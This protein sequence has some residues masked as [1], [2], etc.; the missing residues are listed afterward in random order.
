MGTQP[1]AKKFYTPEEYLAMEETAEYKSEYYQGEIF[2]MAGGSIDYNRIV[3]N[4]ENRMSKAFEGKDCEV[5]FNDMRLRVDAVDLFT[6]PDLIVICGQPKFYENRRDTILN[7]LLIVEVLSES[8]KNYDRG[9]KFRLYRAIPT[10]REYTLVDQYKIHV[11]QFSLGQKG[12]WVLTEYD[13]AEAVLH[14]TS[15]DFQIPLTEIYSKVE[16]ESE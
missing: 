16:L 11:E 3:R 8:T 14:C 2:A 5:F 12:K 9:E 4:L 1:L 7:P 13:G 10:L 15:V 6:Y